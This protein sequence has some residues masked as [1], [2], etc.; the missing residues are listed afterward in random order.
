SD[1]GEGAIPRLPLDLE[2]VLFVRPGGIVAPGEID[3]RVGDRGGGEPRRCGRDVPRSG[4][5]GFVGEVG[6]AAG[7]VGADAVGVA[8]IG[9]EA[10]IRV[11]DD[12]RP[13]GRDLGE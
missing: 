7:V 2:A 1:L 3:L 5:G 12:V 13:H 8:G 6:V 11:A 10:G 4:G 9:G